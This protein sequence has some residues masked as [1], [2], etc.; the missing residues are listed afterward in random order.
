MV[1]LLPTLQNEFQKFYTQQESTGET[2]SNLQQCLN[3]TRE[4]RMNLRKLKAHLNKQIQEQEQQQQQQQQSASTSNINLN[5]N[6]LIPD[7]TP[8]HE[9]VLDSKAVKRRKLIIEKVNK[10]HK[11]WEYSIRKN[12]KTS[13]QQ[14]NKFGKI[15]SNRLKEFDIDNV[16]SNKISNLR[17]KDIDDAIG[18]H[19]TRYN[20][21][22]LPIS[23]NG[24]GGE[25]DILQYLKTV[26]NVDE[27][28]SKKF[29]EMGTI[30]QDLKRED[31]TSCSRWLRLKEND[32]IYRPEFSSLEFE[33]Y[34][35]NALQSIKKGEDIQAAKYF[36]QEIPKKLVMKKEKEIFS[37]ISPLLTSV[38]LGEKVPNLELLIN[39]QLE[40]CISL[41]TTDFCSYYNLPIDSPIFL[42]TLSGLISFQFFIKYKSIRATAHVD[43]STKDE[44][45]F[46]VKL[47]EFLTHFHPV[48]ICPVLKEETTEENPPFSLSCHHIISR[49]ALDRL[50]KNGAVTFKCPY[51]PVNSSRAKTNRVEFLQ[52]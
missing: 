47:P 26:Y 31:S 51:C 7:Q 4:F 5:S 12:L 17:R 16:Y 3:D 41:F 28:I 11:Q 50:S 44:L 9:V 1:G 37:K 19:I 27:G 14:Y 43:W 25:E 15:I 33:L 35:F 20:V 40:K 2:Q 38:I 29:V 45:P 23:S 42:I 36:I 39:E 6:S 8:D 18:Y 24:S 13:S 49:K 10:S 52:I 48:F 21:G 32:N 34:I 46:D 30:I 22:D